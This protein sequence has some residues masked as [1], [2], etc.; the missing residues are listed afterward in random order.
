MSGAL[1][2]IVVLDVTR[3]FAPSMTAAFLG[4][5]GARVIR[6]EPLGGASQRGGVDEDGAVAGLRVMG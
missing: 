4:D 1:D 2:D 5:F 3:G 6:L